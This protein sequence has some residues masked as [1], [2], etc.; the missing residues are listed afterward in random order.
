MYSIS[1]SAMVASQL[2][3]FVNPDLQNTVATAR[4]NASA[5]SDVGKR[6]RSPRAALTAPTRLPERT[7]WDKV[8][9]IVTTSQGQGTGLIDETRP[10]SISTAS[11]AVGSKPLST[12]RVNVSAA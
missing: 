7:S 6:S 11:T 12:E 2:A 10:P 3:I 8:V 4:R 1:N 9:A 5:R